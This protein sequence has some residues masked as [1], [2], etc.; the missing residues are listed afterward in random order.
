[1]TTQKEMITREQW[2]EALESGEH[3]AIS[4]CDLRGN[5]YFSRGTVF[6]TTPK[7]V[8]LATVAADKSQSDGR[9]FLRVNG[10]EVGHSS[11]KLCPIDAEVKRSWQR[12]ALMRRIEETCIAITSERINLR[13]LSDER[14]KQ[15]DDLFAVLRAEAGK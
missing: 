12:A 3:V 5:V 9:K 4:A 7:Y 13:A 1:M 2:L 8:I 10:S 6:R 15:L 14:L 11:C